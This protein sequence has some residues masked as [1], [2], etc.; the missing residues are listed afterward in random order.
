MHGPDPDRWDELTLVPARLTVSGGWAGHLPFAFWLVRMLRPSLFVELG[1]HSAESYFGV[2]QALALLN[3][4][5]RACAVGTWDGGGD[6]FGDVAA[7]NAVAY[8]SFSTMLRAS[9]DEARTGIAD[10]SVDLLHLTG[11]AGSD[12]AGQ[13][14]A[15]WHSALSPRGVVL[16]S[17]TAM[18]DSATGTAPLWQSLRE[19]FPHFEFGHAGGLGVLGVGPDQAQGLAD[20]FGLAADPARAA[21]VRD[22][23]AA[24][25][26]ALERDAE[27]LALHSRLDRMAPTPQPEPTLPAEPPA[28][29]DEVVRALEARLDEQGAELAA[30]QQALACEQ[31]RGARAETEAARL[32]QDLRGLADRQ[33][34]R[35]G[36]VARAHEQERIAAA[37]ALLDARQAVQAAE[38]RQEQTVQAYVR[39]TSWRL[40][41]PLRVTVRLARGGSLHPA[42][43]PAPPP[44]TLPP[45]TLAFPPPPPV[46]NGAEAA[47]AAMRELLRVRLDAFLAGSATLALPRADAPEV[48][49]LL[50]LF[51][52]AEL[53][54]ACLSSIAETLGQ[55]G[56]PAVEVVIVDN[57]SSD[58]TGA[59]LARTEG[60]T[61]VRNGENLHF[62]RAVNAGARVVR[63]QAILLLNN[64]ALLLPGAVAAAL[65]T[66][67]SAPDIGAVGG[68]IILPDGTLQEAGSIIWRS[69]ACVG[70][71]RGDAPGASRYGFQRDVDF[72]SGAFLLTPTALWQAIEGFDERFAPA[73]YEEVDYCVRLWRC[74]FRVVFDP[75]AT[76]VHYEF[77]S[78]A[79]SSDAL[80]LQ[81]A[82]HAVFTARHAEWLAGKPEASPANLFA[83]SDAGQGRHVLVAGPPGEGTRWVTAEAVAA[84]L[85]VTVLAT[86]AGRGA[87]G[88]D[89]RVEVAVA[90]GAEG[91]ASFLHERTGHY[92]VIVCTGPPAL[93]AA[94]AAYAGGV[95][96]LALDDTKALRAALTLPA[97]VRPR[98]ELPTSRPADADVAMAVPFRFPPIAGQAPRVGVFCHLFHPELATEVLPY[99][100]N[101]PGRPGLHVSTD[102]AEKAGAI[103]AAL[104]GR[105]GEPAD[106]RV[107]PNRGRDIA[108]KLVG[109]AAAHA[110]YD[111][112]LHLH[113]KK[114]DHASF[115]MPWRSFLFENLA[116]SPA[117]VSSVL[118]AFARLP[119]LG[120]LAAQHF[121]PIRR[122]IGW[123]GNFAE[124]WAL[125]RR[126]G[127]PL[128]AARALDFP[129]GSMF[130]ARPAALQPLFDLGLSWEDFP[131]EGGEKDHTVAHAVE[132]LFFFSCER[133]GLSWLK[134]ADPAL[135]HDAAAVVDVPSP[136][137]LAGFAKTHAVS[138]SGN[139]PVAV[140]P[141]P[142]PM[143]TQVAPGL[144]LRLA[145]RRQ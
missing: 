110:G 141:E 21:R 108:A 116:G 5:G 89:R 76:I 84:G 41:R 43:I 81:A 101:I 83:A 50:V 68:R 137:A 105:G 67:R 30:A 62:L 92:E 135:F 11:L 126:M 71:G 60:A 4:G 140:R 120:L 69:G 23:L 97:P 17:R 130:W 93:R 44:A 142:A 131:C 65:R 113:G 40:T 3:R 94:L 18:R 16:L 45:A 87:A 6:A 32:R 61:L 133:S 25:G 86:P 143:M 53:T 33:Q 100:E 75:D 34:A 118:D 8:G 121:E 51:N 80:A 31:A 139:E 48:S 95:P 107:F 59:L 72:C 63:G 103:R 57:A 27:L 26:G 9:A 56:A 123:N 98:A 90:E 36:Q 104:A 96:V 88:L 2:C 42:A 19:C 14:L 70:Y 85:R 112:V 39:S 111:L 7:Y 102:T 1:A 10:G 114:S 24:R 38:L 132:R 78:S 13:D 12:S 127:V 29:L 109:F 66:L 136:E 47:K 144:A 124:A 99:L 91:I 49:V 128:R 129:S 73:Y 22:R 35:L 145:S 52:Q 82:N 20:L 106:I 115:L 138:L 54:F 15:A 79:T 37:A 55:P 125:A 74:G 122:W 58:A 46:P 28:A 64:D 117:V 77:G 134:I 119:A